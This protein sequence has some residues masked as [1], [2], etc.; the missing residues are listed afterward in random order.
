MEKINIVVYI[1]AAL[2]L[3]YLVLVYV[4][5]KI[6]FSKSNSKIEKAKA[7]FKEA[8]ELLE[9][10]KQKLIGYIGDVYGHNYAHMVSMG[11]LWEG[12][13]LNLLMLAKGRADN[14]KQTAD[15]RAIT[16]TWIYSTFDDR[17]GTHKPNLEVIL[18]NNLVESWV[19]LN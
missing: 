12:M 17:S 15:A 3:L 9:T 2:C 13:P 7:E 14:V 1:V 11:I 18:K 16:Q 4:L 8:K 5:Q 10:N 19:E 6:K